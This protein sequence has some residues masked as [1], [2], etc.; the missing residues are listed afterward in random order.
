MKKFSAIKIGLLG[1][2]AM[3]GSFVLYK[4]GGH[5]AV[6]GGAALATVPVVVIPKGSKDISGIQGF[7]TT[8]RDQFASTATVY[9]GPIRDLFNDVTT[10]LEAAL[11]AL[12]K[13]TDCNWSL[14][15]KLE[16]FFSL[17][18]AANNVVASLGLELNKLKQEHASALAA[19]KPVDVEAALATRI[20]ER[21][22]EK[23]DLTT[24]ELTQQLCSAAKLA[25]IAEGVAQ[26]NAE[27][28]TEAAAIAT[29]AERKTAL[30]TASLPLPEGAMEALLRGTAEAF[31]AAKTT[32]ADRL[33]KFTEAGITLPPALLG[34]VWLG[35]SDYQTFESTAM[36]C[37]ASLKRTP[38][39][40][41]EPLA[42]LVSPAAGGKIV[43]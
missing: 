39:K 2:L 3:A 40:V 36:G 8:I 35:A 10:K 16:Q 7:L 29:A 1:L 14:D 12:P 22:G 32:A 24:K 18:A 20:A 17:I 4:L 19:I 34:N 6:A 33:K 28:A 43:L 23:G 9:E 25:G 11:A 37:M 30:T 26:R 21:T 5:E 42:G 31:E 15:D 38:A 13:T 41:D 27:L